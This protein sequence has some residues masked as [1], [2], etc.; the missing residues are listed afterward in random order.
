MRTGASCF[1]GGIFFFLLAKLRVDVKLGADQQMRNCAVVNAGP[2]AEL[3]QKI[4]GETKIRRGV[5][6]EVVL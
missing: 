1:F 4:R 5:S 3:P 2:A 6:T